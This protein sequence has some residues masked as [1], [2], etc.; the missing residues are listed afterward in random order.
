[1]RVYHFVE[2]Y[3]QQTETFIYNY[4]KASSAVADEVVIV[5]FGEENLRQF[6][7]PENASILFLPN[8]NYKRKTIKGF[9]RF[10]REKLIG[11]PIWYSI[12]NRAINRGQPD[13]YY[14]GEPMGVLMAKFVQKRNIDLK[15]Y[16]SFYG[17]DASSLS[18]YSKVYK[19][20]LKGI[21]R[22][23]TLLLAEGPSMKEKI[24][25]L[26]ASD[27]KIQL[28]PIIID[29]EK[30][31]VYNTNKFESRSDLIRF[32]IIGRFR[33]KKGIH[34]FLEAIGKIKEEV[35]NFLITIVGDGPM[36]IKYDAIIKKYHLENNIQYKGLIPLTQCIELMMENDVFA[37]PSVTA[38]DGDSEGGAPTVL[39][40][41]QF[42]GIPIIASMHAD[43]PFVMGYQ[44]FLAKEN[45]VEDLILIIRKFLRTDV[46]KLKK[47]T[48]KGR[49]HVLKYHTF[50]SDNYKKIIIQ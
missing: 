41:A 44:D 39:I 49:R 23:A 27:S 42:V 17:Y 25:I 28:N 16:V 15:Y 20:G 34:L 26:G 12:L 4:I 30:Y 10:I 47:F 45:D 14:N 38:I 9:V 48:E 22:T 29:H 13:T 6:P 2:I 40:E 50:Q 11:E 46:S 24:K 18:Y 43:I 32:L 37:H 35:G 33:E 19:D 21:W 36:K 7:L 5:C 8:F 3:L 31:P 1:M